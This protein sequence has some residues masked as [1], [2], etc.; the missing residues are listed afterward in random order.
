MAR[1]LHG[2]GKGI[3]AAGI[4]ND[5]AKLLGRLDGEQQPIE[6]ESLVEDI[7]IG[8]QRGVGRN[9]IIVAVQLDPVAGIIDDGDVGLARLAAE[10]AQ[11]LAHVDDAQVE[12]DVHGVEAGLP[13]HASD[14]RGVVHRIG[15]PGHALVGGIADDESHALFSVRRS[16]AQAEY[17]QKK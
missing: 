1:A 14:Q 17:R 12:L 5:E 16:A 11:G 15:Q 3:V 7:G 13:E 9:E 4:E 2:L 8:F 6:R 10:L